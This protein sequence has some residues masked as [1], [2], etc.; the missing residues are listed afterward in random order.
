MGVDRD[1]IAVTGEEMANGIYVAMGGARNQ[2]HRLDTLSNDLANANTPGF[3]SQETIYRQIHNDVTALGNPNQ[4]MGLNHPVRFL[5]EDRL[6]SV[7]D[8]RY[9]KFRQ[10]TLRE[11]GNDLDL[12]LNGGGFFTIQGP[13]GVLYSRNGTFSLDKTGTLVDQEGRAVLDTFEKP[14][15]VPN[16][17]GK[18]TVTREGAVRVGTEKIAEL[19]LMG[20]KPAD[21]QKLERVGNSA[22][23]VPNGKIEP[24]ALENPDVRQ[25]YIEMA[26]VNPVHT[27]AML[28][29]TNRIFEFNTR[30]LQAYKAMD[31][32]CAREVGRV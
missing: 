22:Y 13:K 26:N 19:N 10:G 5:P 25:G 2:E 23:Q 6:P 30:A 8:S 24:E 15:Q 29:K 11:T 4:A 32:Q 14:I 9:T 1:R 20:F 7:M 27:M 12:A 3:K 17:A 21:A 16:T 28:I 18:V 31:E